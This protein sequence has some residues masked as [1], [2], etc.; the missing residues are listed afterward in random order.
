MT[1]SVFSSRF[2]DRL[3]LLL[4]DRGFPVRHIDCVRAFASEVGLDLAQAE[5]LLSGNAMPGWD[6]LATICSVFRVEPGYFLDSVAT[7]PPDLGLTKAT[8]ATGGET[9]VW[10]PPSGIG[11]KE[12]IRTGTT[13]WLTGSYLPN[14]NIRYTDVVVF[15][16]DAHTPIKANSSYMLENDGEYHAMVCS[17]VTDRAGVFKLYRNQ[18]ESTLFMPLR[19]DGTLSMSELP[20]LGY[21]G[22]GP[23]LGTIRS[24]VDFAPLP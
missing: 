3:R 6:Q 2:A 17:Q 23:I 21:F 22:V 20:K 12:A 13:R 11:G 5:H 15:S 18:E 9:I 19:A 24:A 8:G 1:R 10:N 4:V 7:P 16:T 14:E